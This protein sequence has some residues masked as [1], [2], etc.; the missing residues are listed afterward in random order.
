MN[1]KQLSKELHNYSL[2][3]IFNGGFDFK[4]IGKYLSKEAKK[5]KENSFI[6]LIG[7]L[8]D[9][10]CFQLYSSCLYQQQ[11]Q[12]Y[13]I[14]RNISSVLF[15]SLNWDADFFRYPD[16]EDLLIEMPQDK[17][18]LMRYKEKV[19][20]WFLNFTHKK[21][22]KGYKLLEELEDSK[23][24]ATTQNSIL[25]ASKD[26]EWARLTQYNPTIIPV[27]SSN[28]KE[29][30]R[31]VDYWFREFSVSLYKGSFNNNESRTF[32]IQKRWKHEPTLSEI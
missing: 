11:I 16:K 15:I 1:S 6:N 26:F 4:N 2:N 30:E 8:G 9:K 20:S 17:K 13:Q 29:G 28:F 31:K 24:I 19:I 10:A 23:V 5:E 18:I 21:L 3:L 32:L 14:T 22:K 7:N 25:E 12:E 27:Y